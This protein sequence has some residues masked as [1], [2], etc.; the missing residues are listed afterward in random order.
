MEQT[1][2]TRPI[3]LQG[4]QNVCRD[5]FVLLRDLVDHWVRQQRGIGR[6][7]RRVTG[8]NNAL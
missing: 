6:S 8:H 1:S 2:D 5:D 3:C 4:Y 7:Q